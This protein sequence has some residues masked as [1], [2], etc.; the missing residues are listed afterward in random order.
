MGNQEYSSLMMDA[1]QPRMVEEQ[2]YMSY[3][4]QYHYQDEQPS[5]SYYKTKLVQDI[6]SF[7]DNI[8]ISI[9]AGLLF[10]V[11]YMVPVEMFVFKYVSIEHVPNANILV[12]SLIMVVLM[13]ICQKLL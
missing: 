7:N 5:Q 6:M 3:P 9:V 10:V 4:Q 1:T 13:I 11:L 2:Q 12:K 8:K